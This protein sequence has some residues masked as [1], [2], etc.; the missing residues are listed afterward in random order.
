MAELNDAI[1][2]KRCDRIAPL[3]V[4]TIRGG[5]PL[6]RPGAPPRRDECPGLTPASLGLAGARFI[7]DA[8]YGTGAITETAAKRNGSR[9]I[10]V[11]ALDGDGRFR[12]TGL[13]ASE[14]PQIGTR[15]VSPT[16]DDEVARGFVRAVR[17]RD[18]RQ[19]A[20]LISQR[21][22]LAAL[23]GRTPLEN[24]KLLVDGKLFAPAAR[25]TPDGVPRRLGATS[26]FA[27]YG[28]ATKRGYFTI[29]L[30]PAEQG[31]AVLDVLAATPVKP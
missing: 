28:L 2:S 18:C 24:C 5:R 22:R 6:T 13:T 20:E 10:Q 3:R 12:I 30:G 8:T 4:S 19:L 31:P 14:P 17:A 27:F 25:S 21:S 15:P 16:R 29:V 1:A 26:L 23:G 11:W 7:R 9:T